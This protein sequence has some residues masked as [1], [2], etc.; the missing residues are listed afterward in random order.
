MICARVKVLKNGVANE[1]IVLQWQASMNRHV[2]LQSYE[3]ATSWCTAQYKML[4]FVW[5]PS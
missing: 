2:R 1:D 4:L 3:K 5:K